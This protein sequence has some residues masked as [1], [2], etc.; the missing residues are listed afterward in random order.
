MDRTK[1]RQGEA[2]ILSSA[3]LWSLFPVVTILSFASVPSIVSLAWSTLFSALFFVLVMSVKRRWHELGKWSVYKDMLIGTFIQGICYYFLFFFALK[4]TSAGNAALIMSTEILFTY[5]FF[6]FGRNYPLSNY[7]TIGAF[8]MLI[9]AAVV[10]Y[11]NFKEFHRGDMLIVLA[12]A[13]APVGNFF[14]QRARKSVGSE[15][16]MLVRS[17]IS[18]VVIFLVVYFSGLSSS[19][20]MIEPSLFLLIVNGFLLLG[21]TKLFWLEGIHKI[22][23][24]KAIALSNISPLLTLF[25][26]WFF[27][28]DIPTIWQLMAL[29]PMFFGIRFL[30]KQT[31]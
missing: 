3:F 24:T 1:E 29:I 8:L 22:S 12:C 2:F 19:I 16:I 4:Y 28:H 13:I 26:A 5:L 23:V 14:Q 15:T 11:P 30:Q 6:R 18:T 17:S 10:L 21:L 27:L 7:H 9:G 31:V 25:F 20:F